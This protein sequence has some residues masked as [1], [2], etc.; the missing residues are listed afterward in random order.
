[1]HGIVLRSPQLLGYFS[2]EKAQIE[3]RRADCAVPSQ[4]RAQCHL[5]VRE[6]DRIANIRLNRVEARQR[7]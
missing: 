2:R 3:Q 6:I 1:M 5:A 7:T 4:P